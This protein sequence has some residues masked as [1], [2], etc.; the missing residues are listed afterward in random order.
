MA[1]RAGEGMTEERLGNPTPMSVLMYHSISRLDGGRLRSLAVEP[2]R[3]TDHLA[4]LSDAGYRLVG[5]SAAL[6]SLAAGQSDTPQVA[7]TFDDGYANF[8][9]AGLPALTAAGASATLYP[10][11]G[12]LGGNADWL[13]RQADA[14]GPLLTW[15]QLRD[16]AE[17]GVEIGN[18]GLIHHPLDVLPRGRLEQE[19]RD[20]RDRLEQE[21]SRPIRSFCYPHGYHNPQVQELVRAYGHDNACE[22]GRRRYRPMANTRSATGAGDS[23][24]AIPRL[25]PTPDLTGA[26]LLTL[27]RGHGPTIGP[28]VRRLAQPAWRLT[29][30]L[31]ARAGWRLT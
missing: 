3:L 20:S 21:L 22:V 12:S 5:L 13:G 24:M 14:F 10:A 11:V 6:D 16:V 7:L 19:I 31:A 29:R 28:E 8:L 2:R 9:T 23:R 15:E 17:A 25:Q 18:H 4:T 30:R 26:D 27:V 1:V